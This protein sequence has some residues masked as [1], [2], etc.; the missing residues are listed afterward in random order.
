MGQ[1][2]LAE[3]PEA[4]K[5]VNLDAYRHRAN[6]DRERAFLPPLRN[7]AIWGA[8]GLGK[9]VVY[10]CIADTPL[11]RVRLV[12]VVK[13]QLTFLN[14]CNG[15]GGVGPHHRR[16]VAAKNVRMETDAGG[17]IAG[18]WEVSD[19]LLMFYTHG[20]DSGWIVTLMS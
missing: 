19:A 3:H 18:R 15:G 5:V 16:I 1:Q 9:L 11:I 20:K 17:L 13:K 6:G 10:I 7:R 12:N 14:H 8:I 2:V 4:A